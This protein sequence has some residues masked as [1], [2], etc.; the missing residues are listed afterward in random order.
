MLEDH[1]APRLVLG[2]DL[3]NVP[4]E[5][6]VDVVQCITQALDERLFVC[7]RLGEAP[8]H[9]IDVLKQLCHV[10]PPFGF[11]PNRRA[12]MRLKQNWPKTIP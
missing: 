3:S 2:G 1:R 11:S 8:T 9:F 12:V 10:Q 5:L 6:L 4:N 7:G